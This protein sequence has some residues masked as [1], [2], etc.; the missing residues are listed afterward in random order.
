MSTASGGAFRALCMGCGVKRLVHPGG[1]L[2]CGHCDNAPSCC[3]N[4][5]LDGT[6]AEAV[7]QFLGQDGWVTDPWGDHPDIVPNEPK[8]DLT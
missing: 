6:G 2:I 3:Y 8:Q 1:V 5:H 7:A 4:W